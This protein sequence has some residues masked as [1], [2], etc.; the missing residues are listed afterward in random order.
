MM[1]F[2]FKRTMAFVLAMALLL[3]GMPNVFTV[4]ADA[5]TLSINAVREPSWSCSEL[6]Y[7]VMDSAP[8][9]PVNMVFNKGQYWVTGFVFSCPQ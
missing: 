5:E 2:S 4:K 6:T 9:Y 3:C 8:G 1:K 7:R